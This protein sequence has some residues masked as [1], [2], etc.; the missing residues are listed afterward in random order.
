MLVEDDERVR[1]LTGRLLAGFG[2]NVLPADD[3][4]SAI[5]LYEKHAGRIHLMLTAI[6]MPGTMNGVQLAEW[7]RTR[8]PQMKVVCMSG[9]AS[10]AMR[11]AGLDRLGVP[12]VAKPFSVQALARV[13]RKT[14]D[15]G[16]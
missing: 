3:A 2:Y 15:E 16:R 10:E 9:H 6:V 14:L 1:D 5:A 12:L 8:E 7:M 13:L 11:T 4:A